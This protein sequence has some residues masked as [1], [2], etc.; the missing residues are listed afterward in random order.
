MNKIRLKGVLAILLI[1]FLA[2]TLNAQ[3]ID[4]DYKPKNLN[5]AI[6]QLDIL[7]SDTTK[8]QVN[9]MTEEEFIANSHFSTGMWIRNNWGLW[10]GKELAKYFNDLGIYHPDDM[11]GIILTSYYRHLHNQDLKVDEQ[12]KYYQD[13]WRNAQ[14]YDN[15]L[16]NDTAFARQE[17]I[18][19][20][21]SINENNEKLKQQ[22]LIG[23][24]VKAWVDYSFLGSSS[25]IIG[26]IV[27][28]RVC[29]SKSK[30]RLNSPN[31]PEIE[32]KYLEA[33]VKVQEYLEVKKKRRIEKRN[34]MI[35]N[36]VW[37]HV[38]LISKIE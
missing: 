34:N 32:I 15:R 6:T 28:W 30:S 37:I 3:N 4:K 31:G 12:I 19:Y 2:I 23:S 14:D 22:Y 16:K 17:K 13:Y 1:P 5:E 24:K 21:N 27:D 8:S 36:E 29:V 9:N 33:K 20:E 26:E 25:P 18:K 10:K 35:N 7:F 38:D 11:S